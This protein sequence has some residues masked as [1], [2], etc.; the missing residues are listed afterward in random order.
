LE[1]KPDPQEFHPGPGAAGEEKAISPCAR[2]F[3]FAAGSEEQV[4]IYRLADPAA[5]DRPG[6]YSL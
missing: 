1:E 3:G 2:S 4:G 5:G 6:N